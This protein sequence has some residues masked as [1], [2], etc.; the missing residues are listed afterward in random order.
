M[1]LFQHRNRWK[2][3]LF[4]FA[5][6]IIFFTLWYTQRLASSIAKEE[7][8]KATEI[9]DAYIVL[10][11][12]TSDEL[13]LSKALDKIKLNT[14]IPVIWSN[15]QNQILDAKNFDSLKV[16]KNS[17]YLSSELI[18]LKNNHQYIAIA[19]PDNQQQYLFCTHQVLIKKKRL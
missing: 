18:K 7:I 9:A 13:E 10:N 17:S 3:L 14:T 4:L 12:N 5:V 19:L 11:S 16:N 2:I 15:E 8:K 1:N 6:S